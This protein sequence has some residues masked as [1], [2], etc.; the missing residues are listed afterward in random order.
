MARTKAQMTHAK[1]DRERARLEKRARKQAKKDARKQ[2]S[3]PQPDEPS[4]MLSP[5]VT[6]GCG[7]LTMGGTCVEHDPPRQIVFPRG[8][9]YAPTAAAPRP[10]VG[11]LT[12][13]HP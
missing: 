3:E 1:R 12:A 5:C 4:S 2:G 13:A 7:T 9:P 11:E 10:G 8:R 6:P